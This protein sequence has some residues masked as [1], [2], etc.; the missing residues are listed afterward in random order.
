MAWQGEP[1]TAAPVM[2]VPT[3]C[4]SMLGSPYCDSSVPVTES[5]LASHVVVPKIRTSAPEP[6]GLPAATLFLK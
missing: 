5:L 6:A 1:G 4:T 2:S 3:E